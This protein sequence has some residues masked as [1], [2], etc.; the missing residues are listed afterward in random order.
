MK[1]KKVLSLFLAVALCLS[2]MTAFAAGEKS[3]GKISVFYNDEA[4]AFDV[5]PVIENGRTLVPFRAIFETMGCAVNYIQDGG[6]QIVSARR[7]NDSLFITIGEGKMY[8]NDKEIPLDVPAKIKNGRTLVPLRAI[9]EAFECE[10]LWYGDI[11]T[12][13][14]YSPAEAYVVSAEKVSETI[15]ADDGSVL[16]EAVAYYPVIGNPTEIPYLD[17]INSDYKRDAEKFIEEAR[18]KREDALALK[19]QM[20]DSFI[21][22]AYE[23]TFEQTYNIWGNLSFTNYKYIDIGGAHPSTIM[24]SRTFC[25]GLGEEMSI[26]TVLDEERLET[27]LSKY[28]TNLFVEKFK[29]T[30]PDSAEIYTYD[31]VNEYIGYVRFYIT[32]N[33]LVLYFNQGEVAPY[34]FGVV[35]VEIPYDPELFQVDMRYNYVDEYVFEYEYDKGYEWKIFEY[36]EEKLMFTEENTDYPPEEIISEFY[37]VGLS[38]ITVKGIKKGN[39][40]LILAHVRKG[41]GIESADKIL[42]ASFYVDEN[43]KLTLISEEDAM[44]LLD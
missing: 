19:A 41:E 7:A 38:K 16:I 24:E 44:F 17:E 29:E 23:L 10:V 25:I 4:L 43:N 6:R 5:E 14:I 39:A 42:L 9:T 35:S 36:H 26:S 20:G 12:I 30:D 22:F 33:S 2:S 34:A 11:K 37:P 1:G 32:K 28:V 13:A 21:P 40:A 18:E 8:F 3:D 15:K 27:S 31:Y